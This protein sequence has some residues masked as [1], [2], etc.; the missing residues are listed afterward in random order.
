MS[1]ATKRVLVVDDERGLLDLWTA[2]LTQEGYFV[3]TANNGKSALDLIEKEKFHLVI[4]DSIMPEMDGAQL[5]KA[6]K[7]KGYPVPVIVT[8]GYSEMLDEASFK[9]KGAAAFLHKP[10]NIDDMITVV[11]KVL[12]NESAK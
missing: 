1:E 7:V 11:K 2:V 12:A 5:L 9:D 4:T 3:K 8:S 6:I 10:C